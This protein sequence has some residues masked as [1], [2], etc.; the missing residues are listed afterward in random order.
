[1]P[2]LMI[3]YIACNALNYPSGVVPI[4]Y[5]TKDDEEQLDFDFK[6]NDIVSN[7]VHWFYV[8]YSTQIFAALQKI[9]IK[10]KQFSWLTIVHTN[11][12]KAL[13]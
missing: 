13:Q 6:T 5:V 7:S 2:I 1:M 12:W 11:Y 8:V 4:T 10:C 9:E 3:P